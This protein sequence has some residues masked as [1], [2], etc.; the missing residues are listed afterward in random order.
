MSIIIRL[1]QTSPPPFLGISPPSREEAPHSGNA[2]AL[3]SCNSHKAVE[4]FLFVY[5]PICGLCLFGGL[6]EW[7][8]GLWGIC[9][10]ILVRAHCI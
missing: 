5:W 8:E 6:W 3:N 4:A 1:Y 2:F 9:R 7:V 10:K